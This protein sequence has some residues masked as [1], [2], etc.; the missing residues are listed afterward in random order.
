[1]KA[2]ST[3][4]TH[5]VNK[6]SSFWIMNNWMMY[7]SKNCCLMLDVVGCWT[8]IYKRWKTVREF[9]NYIIVTH[10]PSFITFRTWSTSNFTSEV[11]DVP[12]IDMDFNLLLLLL[13]L[14]WL[15]H[16]N[17]MAF[18]YCYF[19]SSMLW[20]FIVTISLSAAAMPFFEE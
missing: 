11:E 19:T 14:L 12:E 2:R 18:R 9:G 8:K 15:F 3:D 20:L 16:F 1:M 7:R 6:V 17:A 4:W 13:L 10:V 5:Q